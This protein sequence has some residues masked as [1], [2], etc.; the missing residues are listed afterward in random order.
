MENKILRALRRFNRKYGADK[1]VLHNNK[2]AAQLS[3]EFQTSNTESRTRSL[4]E[5]YAQSVLSPL[6]KLEK[7][8]ERRTETRATS[9]ALEVKAINKNTF[10]HSIL[11]TEIYCSK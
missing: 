10:E 11:R 1:A 3:E 8:K 2:S 6:W 9:R 5:N 4:E 7:R